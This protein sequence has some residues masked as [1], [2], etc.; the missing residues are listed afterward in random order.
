M[1]RRCLRGDIEVMCLLVM[2]HGCAIVDNCDV[3]CHV[4]SLG[5]LIILFDAI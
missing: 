5:I 2:G 4:M 1:S 3:A